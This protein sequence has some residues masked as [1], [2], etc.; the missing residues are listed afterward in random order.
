MTAPLLFWR[1]AQVRPCGKRRLE[2]SRARAASFLEECA[3]RSSCVKDM[4]AADNLVT[5]QFLRVF[6]AGNEG[7]AVSPLLCEQVSLFLRVF[8]ADRGNLQAI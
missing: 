2:P 4:A 1:R 8:S 7:K 6:S 3:R 5:E